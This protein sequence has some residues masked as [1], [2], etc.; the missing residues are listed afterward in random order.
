M[1]TGGQRNRERPSRLAYL[2]AT[3]AVI[4]TFLLSAC[5][6]LATFNA[7]APA[8]PGA[9]ISRDIAYGDGA[10]QRLNV[11]R[12]DHGPRAAPVVVFLYGGSWNSG[13]KDDNDFVGAAFA[14]NGFVV[15]IPDYR[16]VPEVRYPVFLDDNA[17][18]LRWAYD[19]IADYGGDP[20]RIHL[21][22]HSAGAYNVMMVTLDRSYLAHVGLPPN[23]IKS[24]AALAGP[25]DF[26]PFDVDA[27][28]A[29][30]GGAADPAA[31]QPIHYARSSAPPI[32]LATGSDDR[33]VYPRNTHALAAK[34][35]E[36]GAIVKE[37]TYPGISHV[38]ILLAISK[39]FRGDAPVLSDVVD[40]FHA[41]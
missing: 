7:L 2:W 28:I 19:H 39:P 26:L 1:S 33:T 27:T 25:Y 10:R 15:V 24:A 34:L 18:A 16:L 37:T 22:G 21:L 32:F 5:S 38:G 6:P 36:A 30:F 35:R 40:F 31:T 3:A 13:R 8:D 11:Y 23:A 20:H 14:A 41:H 29:A 4:L 9:L 12:P 17:A